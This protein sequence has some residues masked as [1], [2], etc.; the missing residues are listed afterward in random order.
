MQQRILDLD[1]Q[2]LP[3]LYAKVDEQ[4]VVTVPRLQKGFEKFW[5]GLPSFPVKFRFFN[6]PTSRLA[7]GKTQ[8]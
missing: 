5:E 3:D 2:F 4:G 1:P 6:T 8:T 7:N